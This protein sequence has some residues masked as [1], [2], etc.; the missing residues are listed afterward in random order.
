MQLHRFKKHLPED[1]MTINPIE[2]ESANII[3]IMKFKPSRK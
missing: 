3:D 1:F 2:A